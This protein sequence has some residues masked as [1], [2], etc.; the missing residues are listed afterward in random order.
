MQ[1][2]NRETKTT[3]LFQINFV[4]AY[5]PKL[6]KTKAL[7]LQQKLLDNTLDFD[8]TN[9]TEKQYLLKR[10]NPQLNFQINAPA[11][12]LT[13]LTVTSPNPQS[14]EEM[15]IQEASA[16]LNAW[17]ACFPA[18]AYQLVQNNARLHQLYSC[19]DHAFKY[20]WEQRL[21]QNPAQFKTLGNRIIAGGGIRLVLPPSQSENQPS[22]ENPHSI[23]IRIES[24]FKEPKKL[25]IE[26]AFTWP[27]AQTIRENNFLVS[28]KINTVKNFTANEVWNFITA[29][30]S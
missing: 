13:A 7:Q 12:N 29:D 23:Q 6:D 8:Q 1:I 14:D 4:I 15:F 2:I 17:S 20:L 16:A 19:S 26:T 30:N 10:T 3:I 22:D 11:P 21:N 25:F 18:P 9:L 5:P 28:E 27:K 24:F